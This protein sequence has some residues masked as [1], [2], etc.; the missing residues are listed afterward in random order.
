MK[1][2]SKDKHFIKKPIYEGGLTALKLFIKNNL[3]YPEEAK[4][5]K[6]EGTVVVKYTVNYKGEVIEARALKGPGYGCN[7]EA[8]RLSRLLKFKIPK[9]RKI[10]I[11]FHKSIQI[12]FRLPKDKPKP[13]SREVQYTYTPSAKEDK[14]ETHSYSIT[15]N[16]PPSRSNF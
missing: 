5:H 13:S 10:K 3:K 15:V 11:Q 2:E 6:V 16:F 8:V 14:K 4:L 9:T 7:E 12:H 1:K